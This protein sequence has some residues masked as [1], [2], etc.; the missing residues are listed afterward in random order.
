MHQ[1]QLPTSCYPLT[2]TSRCK[3]VTVQSPP[4]P[5]PQVVAGVNY[6]L[7]LV[8]EDS[9]NATVNVEAVMYSTPTSPPINTLTNVKVV[10]WQRRI[11]PHARVCCTRTLTRPCGHTPTPG[12]VGTPTCGY[13]LYAPYSLTCTH[14]DVC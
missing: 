6:Y 12:H 10:S 13:A 9:T 5:T 2:H 3:R 14:T 8:L 1:L 11:T 4:P 7:L